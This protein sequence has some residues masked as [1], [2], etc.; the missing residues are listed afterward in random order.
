M[1]DLTGAQQWATNWGLGKGVLKAGETAT[2]GLLDSRLASNPTLQNEYAGARTNFLNTSGVKPTTIASQNPYQQTALYTMGQG[3]AFDSNTVKPLQAGQTAALGSA[4][5]AFDAAGKSYDP[6]SYKPLMNPYIE[7]VINRNAANTNRQAAI[8]GNQINESS[9]E[10]GGYG[11]T[12][13]GVERSLNED[14]RV[15]TIADM[16][17]R[18]RAQGFDTA[19][20]NSINLFQNDRSTNLARGSG[21]LSAAGGYGGAITDNLG[22]DQY[23]RNVTNQNTDRQLTA[24]NQIQGQNQAEL[25]AYYAEQN[26][27]QNYPWQQNQFLQQILQGYPTGVTSTATTPGV[28]AVQ[29]GIGGALIGSQIGNY[30]QPTK[31]PWQ[32]AGNVNPA[33]GRY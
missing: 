9:A 7:E 13:L 12:A 14:N 10:A 11:S 29:G 33:G 22:V 32:T 30:Y 8:R 16:D 27:A 2:N 3:Q 17:A 28:G 26:K 24:G 1:A 15:R 25:D 6:N 23:G 4:T 18:L 21:Y 20:N 19:Q 5:A 31:L